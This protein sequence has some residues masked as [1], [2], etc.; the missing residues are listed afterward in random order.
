MAGWG[1]TLE[2]GQ[3]NG[4]LLSAKVSNLNCRMQMSAVCTSI[5]SL[6]VPLVDQEECKTMYGEALYQV[7]GKVAVPV[8]THFQT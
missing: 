7:N 5:W 3:I 4:T 1:A 6:K 2:G 8:F